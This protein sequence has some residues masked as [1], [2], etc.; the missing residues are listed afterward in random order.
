MIEYESKPGIIFLKDSDTK[1]YL[2]ISKA[3]DSVRKSVRAIEANKRAGNNNG[4][5]KEM[6]A[7]LQQNPYDIEV[8]Y[9]EANEV[10]QLAA[11]YIFAFAPKFNKHQTNLRITVKQSENHAEYMRQYFATNEEQR[12]KKN[13]RDAIYYREHKEYFKEYSKK[14][15]EAHK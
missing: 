1:E 6:Y 2:Y 14:Y 7:Y 3:T 8:K 12:R 4:A 15:R 5:Q 9:V 10:R 11:D 13:E